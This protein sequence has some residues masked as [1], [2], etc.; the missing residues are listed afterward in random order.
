[1]IRADRIVMNALTPPAPH[2]AA[3]ATGSSSPR[4]A[5]PF[6]VMAKPIGPICNLACDYCYYLAKTSLFPARE[7]YR[8]PDAVLE[9]HIRAFIEASPGPVVFFAWHGGE[10]TLAG[11]PFFRRVVELQRRHLPAGW[12]CINNLQT[13]GTRLDDA[14]CAFLAENRFAVGLSVDGPARLHDRGRP[15][16]RGRPTHARVMRGLALLRAHGIEP[17]ILCTLNAR[18]AEAPLEVY[19]F[20]LDA[21]VR[22]LQFLPVVERDAAGGV[23]ERSV[24]PEAV[25][26]F[27]GAV[28]D[29]WVRHDV[30]RIAVQN[31]AEAL[32]VVS[33]K[34][35]NL[36][37][38]AETC[39]RVL[40]LEHDGGV[41]ACDHFV[42]PA[43]RLGSVTD[44][45][46]SALV[47]SPAQ[48]AFGRSKQTSLPACCRACPVLFLCNGGCPKDRF[49]V[50][51]DGEAGLNHLCAGYRRSFEHMLPYLRRMVELGRSGRG[52]AAIMTALAADERE[53]RQRWRAA[54]RN[55]PCPCGSGRKYKHCCLEGRR[56]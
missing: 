24:D 8:M 28:F 50:A 40:A 7:R 42:D 11:L 53:E 5:E 37:V 44:D 55:D 10:P 51:P 3:Q 16:R 21:G 38:M 41:Y 43:H 54:S 18:T 23:T 13:N 30:G 19:R 25:A 2:A 52:V 26:D 34:P 12:S 35:A 47:D 27:L 48:L 1:M 22:W 31:F 49:A 45:G 9:A 6:V 4:P 46:L 36:C 39:G 29:E 15:D 20:F 32:L 33:G 17:D 14:W 56:R